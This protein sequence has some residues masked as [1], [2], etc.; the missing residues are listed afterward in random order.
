M[1]HPPATFRPAHAWLTAAAPL[2]TRRV[3]VPGSRLANA[4]EGVIITTMA[5]ITSPHYIHA[6]HFRS[7]G[8]PDANVLIDVLVADNPSTL[9]DAQLTDTHITGLIGLTKG[10]TA[11]FS[12]ARLP[13]DRLNF[14]ALTYYKLFTYN[15]SATNVGLFAF[16]EL[17]MRG[18]R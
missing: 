10:Y 4:N 17:T 5:T 1:I 18:T 8:N 11:G 6:V 15:G 3:Y 2:T 14:S 9:A 7:N 12:N 13:I 16:L